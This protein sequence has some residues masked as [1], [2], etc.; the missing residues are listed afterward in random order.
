MDYELFMKTCSD[1]IREGSVI[2]RAMALFIAKR[3]NVK[4]PIY[5]DLD[6]SVYHILN[7]YIKNVEDTPIEEWLNTDDAPFIRSRNELRPIFPE[8]NFIKDDEKLVKVVNEFYGLDLNLTEEYIYS[9]SLDFNSFTPIDVEEVNILKTD[10]NV[11]KKYGYPTTELED[12]LQKYGFTEEQLK[13][14]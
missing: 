2:Y 7:H 12:K 11:L 3:Y 8:F 5:G 10:I 13:V 4:I 1:K 14:L 9:L 6:G